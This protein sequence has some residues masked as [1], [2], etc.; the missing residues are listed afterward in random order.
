MLPS[1]SAL[2]S[3]NRNRRSNRVI[4][5]QFDGKGLTEGPTVSGLEPTS[6]ALFPCLTWPPS[7]GGRHGGA[8]DSYAWDW[9]LL[10]HSS[11]AGELACS[12]M[13]GILSAGPGA[14][15][16]QWEDQV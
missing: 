3:P 14:A 1:F 13:K 2:V 11:R 15:H 12:Q 10:W 5:Q 16:E 6:D 9:R 7:F 4:D 8:Q